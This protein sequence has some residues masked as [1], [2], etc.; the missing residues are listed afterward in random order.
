M[1]S[2]LIEL[3]RRTHIQQKYR[4]GLR[5]EISLFTHS[6]NKINMEETTT[7]ARVRKLQPDDL[8]ARLE[9]LT[10][11]EKIST[12]NQLK[13]LIEDEKKRLEEQLELINL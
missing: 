13:K 6:L 11:A 9:K 2:L 1:S 7:P 4:A 12:L 8:I 5:T 10:L 3:L